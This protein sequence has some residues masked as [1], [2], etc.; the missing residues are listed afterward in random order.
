MNWIE[1]F[2]MQ[3]NSKYDDI[4]EGETIMR[5][6]G[7]LWV[8]TRKSGHRRFF[9]VLNP[10]NANFADINGKYYPI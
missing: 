10:K 9:V 7:D 8:V 2:L 4:E 5:T 1:A 6:L 3:I